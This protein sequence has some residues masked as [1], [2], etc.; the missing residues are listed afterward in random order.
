[1]Q[2]TGRGTALLDANGDG[3]VDIV[4]GNWNGPHRLYVQSRDG[5]E[6]KFTDAATD[7]MAIPSKIRTVIVA[8]F[9]NDGYEEIFYNNIPGENRLFRKLPPDEDWVRINIG[10]AVEVDGMGTG[11]AVGDFDG[12]GMLELVAH[13][14]LGQLKKVEKVRVMWT[15]A[16]VCEFVPKGIDGVI[17]VHYKSAGNCEYD[18]TDVVPNENFEEKD[19]RA[20][21]EAE[22]IAGNTEWK[23][24]NTDDF[25]NEY[26][27]I[28]KSRNRN[29][30]SHK[31]AA[32]L[33][34]RS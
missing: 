27:N 22:V 1:M 33:L 11:G 29:A 23:G 17:E 26:Y 2:Q 32:F 3:L 31:W 20:K 14:G 7:E 9:D 15:D 13:F 18:E 19:C 5:D 21:P 8:D 30:A 34:E 12:D 16:S 25:F 10:D 4:Y 6:V 28:F 24:K